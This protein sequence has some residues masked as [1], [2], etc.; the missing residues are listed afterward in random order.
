MKGP[1][2]ST[3]QGQILHPLAPV[4]AATPHQQGCAHCRHRSRS[5]LPA[6]GEEH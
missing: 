3:Q 1:S 6:A 4:P 2:P 5:Q